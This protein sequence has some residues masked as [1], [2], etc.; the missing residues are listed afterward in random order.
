MHRN[1]SS[2]ALNL[3]KVIQGK[4][5]NWWY[6]NPIIILLGLDNRENETKVQLLHKAKS[7]DAP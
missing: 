7:N 5:D 6:S 4:V 2:L 1:L 3:S